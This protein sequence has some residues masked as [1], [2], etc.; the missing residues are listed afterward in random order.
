MSLI[1]IKTPKKSYSLIRKRSFKGIDCQY[2][3][4]M[5]K[6]CVFLD[7]DGVIN[8]D[9][10]NYVYKPETFQLIHGVPEAIEA[11]KAAGY[12]IIVVT[13]QSGIAKGIYTRNDMQVCHALMQQQLGHRID[14]I[15]YAPFHE[16]VSNSLSRKPGSLM[17]ERAI[18]RFDIDPGKSWMVGDKARD[19][20]PA[21][22]LG[23]NTV[24]VDG[25]SDGG[26]DHVAKDLYTA[27]E[28]ILGPVWGRL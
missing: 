13:N 14:Y 23:I 10:P 22:K 12:L 18:A 20:K 11:I 8:E 5:S 3:R 26:A 19:I 28:H 16:S 21:Q 6:K 2:L 9:S 7:R 15:Y 4:L 25:L 17:F 1:C 27:C 24:Q